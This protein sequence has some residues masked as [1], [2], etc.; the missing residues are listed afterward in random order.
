MRYRHRRLRSKLQAKGSQAAKRL[1]KKLAGKEKR[2]ARH[3][4][5]VIS[6]QIVRLAK[7]TE[8]RIALEDL[9]GIRER[10]TARREQRTVLHSWSFF[11]LRS[12]L[13][14][15]SKL[16]GVKLGAVDPSNTSRT[17]PQCG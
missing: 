13:E 16:A 15:K 14:Y 2:F 9:S 12:F 17:C 1:L 6:Q 8:R 11:Q 5:H 4:N 3:T 10:L 7:D